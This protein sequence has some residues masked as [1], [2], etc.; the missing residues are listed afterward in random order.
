MCF[1]KN[2]SETRKMKQL[3][4]IGHSNHDINCFCNLLK[5]ANIEYLVDVRSVPFSKYYPQ[6]NQERLI[7]SLEAVN[8]KYMFL[9]KELGGRI[10]DIS[11]YKDEVIPD[12]KVGYALH[13]NYESICTKEWFNNGIN[14]L[15]RIV[16]QGNCAI[17]CSEENPEK[18]HRELIIGRRLKELGYC[19]SHIRAKSDTQE[20]LGLF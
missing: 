20:Q 15:L 17:M 11:C 13:L 18:C 5:Q 8:I 16:K 12:K 14:T 19:I 9:G 1:E 6:F 4:S 7:T 2:H 3:Y 10:N